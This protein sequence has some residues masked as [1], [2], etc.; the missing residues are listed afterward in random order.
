MP[1]DPSQQHDTDPDLPVLT[2]EDCG[3]APAELGEPADCAAVEPAS[4]AWPE[5]VDPAAVAAQASTDPGGIIASDADATTSDTDAEANTG[6]D[7]ASID[8]P[9][10]SDADADAQASADSAASASPTAVD[11]AGAAAVQPKPL[12]EPAAVRKAAP[13]RRL[14]RWV[15]GNYRLGNFAFWSLLAAFIALGLWPVWATDLL[16]VVD[17]QSHLHLIKLMHEWDKS[18]LLQKHYTRVDAIVPYLSYYKLVHWMAYLG[19]VEWANR[20]VL[21][22]CLAALPLSALALLRAAGHSRWLVLGVLPWM[23]NADFVMGFFNFLMSIPLFLLVLATHLRLLQK[24]TWKR[25]GLLVALLSVMAITHYLLWAISLALL[26]TLAVVFGVRHGWRRLLWWP[27]RDALLGLPSLGLLLPWFFSYF[28]FAEGVST[29]DQVGGP[30]AGTLTERLAQI[31]SGEHL[32]PID[33]LKQI[34]DCMFDRIGPMNAANSLW[35]RP[36]QLVSTL[37]LAGLLLWLIAAART[38]RPGAV[39]PQGRPGRHAIAVNGTSYIGW[40]FAL[41]LAAYFLLPRH[42]LKP[43][44]LWGVNFRLAE[45]IGVL[46]VCAIPLAPLQPP[47]A[48]RLRVWAGTA[49]LLLAAVAMPVLTTGQFILARTEYGSVREAMAAIP[50]GKKVLVLRRKFDARSMRATLFNGVTE[51]YAVLRGGYVPYSFADT[52]SKPFVVNKKTALPAP[53]WDWHDIFNWQQ[54][55]RY[56]DYIV[57]FAEPGSPRA[58]Y[59][60]QLPSDLPVVYARDYWT[61][62]RNPNPEP[63]P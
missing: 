55:G 31:Y 61:V 52:S 60:D 15:F 53:P 2:D 33:N 46:A 35:D 43:I 37:W 44:W 22:A 41:V 36:G 42:L 56:Y 47:R 38:P 14:P 62:Y 17:G 3:I 26:P 27:I 7:Y 50:S 16:P 13:A 25:A 1:P 8:S 18:P 20:V 40:T 54:H 23:L 5:P 49:L 32:G 6:A 21:S 28:V 24:P 51:W 19:S 29:S 34:V 48:V 57:L 30:Q 59:Q 45:V 4:A 11:S 63:Y 10:A 9:T 12:A 58:P 39:M